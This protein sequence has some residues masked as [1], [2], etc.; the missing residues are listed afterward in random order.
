MQSPTKKSCAPQ[1]ACIEL[2]TRQAILRHIRPK[3]PGVHDAARILQ[4]CENFVK[5]G[6]KVTQD[7]VLLTQV[8]LEGIHQLVRLQHNLLLTL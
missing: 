6:G 1:R 4:R 3:G 2:A 5:V 8:E 7:D